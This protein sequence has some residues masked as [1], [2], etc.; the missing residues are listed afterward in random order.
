M[1]SI[2][3]L[4]GDCKNNYLDF[5]DNIG[6]RVNS[7]K[8][9]L[10]RF[11]AR[12]KWVI[13]QQEDNLLTWFVVINKRNN[14]I[15]YYSDAVRKENTPQ[16]N[17]RV[18]LQADNE[19]GHICLPASAIPFYNYNKKREPYIPKR[20][21]IKKENKFNNWLR[22]SRK[23]SICLK[24]FDYLNSKDKGD[25]ISDI[26]TKLYLSKNRYVLYDGEKVYWLAAKRDRKT[27]KMKYWYRS[28]NVFFDKSEYLKNFVS[29]TRCVCGKY[30]N[31]YVLSYGK[32]K[33]IIDII[34]PE[35][36]TKTVPI[37][38]S[39]F[40][41][42]IHFC[43]WLIKTGHFDIS[44]I[45]EYY[46]GK[47]ILSREDIDNITNELLKNGAIKRNPSGIH[48]YYITSKNYT[49]LVDCLSK[50]LGN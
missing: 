49:I 21:T 20:E 30:K 42:V 15:K 33:K 44:C 39:L 50:Y 35:D 34:D 23:K 37:S 29:M 46:K 5:L 6:F 41:D 12:R 3:C 27:S 7:N 10:R 14:K 28:D 26:E 32:S 11:L 9:N 18:M 19:I 4:E 8:A 47:K 2:K 45:H 40:A 17:I 38:V 13:Q 16:S 48:K 31:F 24:E 36:L 25:I 43:K 1:G 22:K